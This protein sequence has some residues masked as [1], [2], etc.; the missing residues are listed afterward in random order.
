MA[1]WSDG[2]RREGGGRGWHPAG[3]ALA[4]AT[5]LS[6]EGEGAL[7]GGKQNN[8]RIKDVRQDIDMLAR[9]IAG[10]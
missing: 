8:S 10:K 2:W 4:G 6:I 9:P 5:E 7:L 1:L 3:S